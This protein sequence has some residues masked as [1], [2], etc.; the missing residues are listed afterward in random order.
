MRD[1]LLF[2][3]IEEPELHEKEFEDTENTLNQFLAKEMNI[4][5]AIPFHRVHRLSLVDRN[6]SH[7][8]H[9]VA[10][11]RHFKDRESVRRAALKTLK[12]KPFG[13]REQF[14]KEIEDKRK[15]FIRR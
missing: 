9:I 14:P 7:P 10:K 6:Q 3:G 12:N 2:T 11:F 4:K 13:V 5:R 1:N 15:N 8:R